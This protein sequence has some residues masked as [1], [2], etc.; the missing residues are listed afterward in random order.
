MRG[1]RKA[2]GAEARLDAMGVVVACPDAM[3]RFVI[4]RNRKRRG[5]GPGSVRAHPWMA[6]SC[7]ALRLWRRRDES[8]LGHRISARAQRMFAPGAPVDGIG[9]AGFGRKRR[10]LFRESNMVAFRKECPGVVGTGRTVQPLTNRKRP[11]S[12]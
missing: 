5:N 3:V 6:L 8:P 1:P 11:G 12:M 2:R 10:E 7:E 9:D 4:G